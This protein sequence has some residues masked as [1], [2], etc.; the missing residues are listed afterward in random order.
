MSTVDWQRLRLVIFDVD[1]TLYSQS[2]LRPK[3]LVELGL[4]CLRHPSQLRI[5]RWIA[6][7]R[8]CREELAEQEAAGI[9]VAQ[10]ERPARDLGIS[11]DELRRTIELWMYQRPL[12]HLSGCR[13]AGVLE[14]HAALRSAGLPVAVF[15]D[16]PAAAKLEALGLEA[17]WVAIADDPEIDRLKP[18]PAGL[19]KLLSRVGVEAGECL[20]IGDRED[21]DGECA[22]RVGVP[23]LLKSASSDPGKGRFARYSELLGPDGTLSAEFAAVQ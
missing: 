20:L 16:Y 11:P 12:R 2:C 8:R 9:G 15:S 13:F 17:D 7:F 6:T 23:C 3:M 14:L 5:L 18:H 19:E 21:R 22:R 4:Y 1:G 10:F